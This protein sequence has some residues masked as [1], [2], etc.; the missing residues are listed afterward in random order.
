MPRAHLCPGPIHSG[1]PC[2]HLSP[3][4][5]HSEGPWGAMYAEG[6]SLQNYKFIFQICLFSFLG[7]FPK[8]LKKRSILVAEENPKI[9]LKSKKKSRP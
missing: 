9:D 1:G 7:K 2:A 4:P 8:L 6:P 5:I 3:G